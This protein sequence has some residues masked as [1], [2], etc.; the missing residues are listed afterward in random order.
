[1][2]KLGRLHKKWRW[3]SYRKEVSGVLGITGISLDMREIEAAEA[4]GNERAILVWECILY[5]I[6]KYIILLWAV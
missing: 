2:E 3:L 5:R 1:M 4:T 6:K